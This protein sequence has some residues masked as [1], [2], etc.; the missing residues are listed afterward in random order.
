MPGK[1][2][3]A[4]N[5]AS[6]ASMLARSRVTE[7]AEVIAQ[8][9]T[10][11]RDHW[12]TGPDVGS[13]A[14]FPGGCRFRVFCAA[15]TPSVAS[16]LNCSPKMRQPAIELLSWLDLA[17]ST[18]EI[19]PC[20]PLLHLA[21]SWSMSSRL[22]FVARTCALGCFGRA[23]K[24][25]PSSCIGFNSEMLPLRASQHRKKPKSSWGTSLR[26]SCGK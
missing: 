4:P 25:T 13:S 11:S 26:A 24:L 1:V 9:L 23:R 21:M 16:C 7:L 6:L 15:A 5:A 22:V 20:L 3:Q 8:F 18:F 17:P 12:G 2:S 10:S 14:L 19:F